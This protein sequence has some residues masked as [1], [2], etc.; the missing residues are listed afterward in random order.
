MSLKVGVISLG[1]NKNRI[2][3]ECALGLLRNRG[4]QFT[5]D[6]SNAEIL[7]VNTCG[8]IETAKEESIDTIFEMAEYKKTGKCKLLVVTGCLTQRYEKELMEEIPEIDLIM[9]VNQ[10]SKISDAID[11]ALQGKR[12]SFCH[13]DHSYFEQERVLT[14]PFYS[15]YTRIGE[16]CS[17]HCTFCAIPLIRGPYR[18]RDKDCILNEIRS[19]AGKGVVEHILV[20]QDT[21]RFGTDYQ[22]HSALPQLMREASSIKGVE[23][24]RVLYCYPDETSDELLD[25]LSNTPNICKYL[26]IPIQHINSEILRRMHRRGT[27]DDIIR[28]I[29]HAKERNLTLRT[30][31]IVGFPGET[32]D[33]FKELLSFLKDAEIDRV[34]AFMFSAEEDTPAIKLPDQV[35]EEVKQERYNRLMEIQSSISLKNNQKRVGN[36]E[37]VLVTDMDSV[38]H[39]CLGRSEREAPETD[40]E[41]IFTVKDNIPEIGSFVNVKITE[42]LTYDLRGEIYIESSK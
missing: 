31:L 2:D 15:A 40:G 3:T 42:A 9:G 41:I 1:C 12:L 29:Y 7:L 4:Y 25:V 33:S 32:E 11:Q 21:T 23:W 6:P 26:D 10:Y 22:K 16:G 30:S 13:D 28:S 38:H 18:S 14:T 24:L 27:R 20:A 17:N 37:K 35:P 19:L 34:G 5:P 8:F 39:S 36:I